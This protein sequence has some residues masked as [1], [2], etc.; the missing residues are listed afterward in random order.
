MKRNTEG[1]EKL[2]SRGLWC[3]IHTGQIDA[4]RNWTKLVTA[5]ETQEEKK[6]QMF[7]GGLCLDTCPDP[8]ATQQEGNCRIWCNNL[9][10][11]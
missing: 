7:C 5:A 10:G 1:W 8:D 3:V 2:I 11:W 9:L 6:E 4:G